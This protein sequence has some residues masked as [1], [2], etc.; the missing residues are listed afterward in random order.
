MTLPALDSGSSGEETVDGSSSDFELALD[1]SDIAPED[2]SGSQVVALDE[3]EFE[4]GEGDLEAVEEGDI[5]AEEEAEVRE[6][7][8]ER[9]VVRERWIKPAP[10]GALPV[11]FMVPCVAIMVVVGIMGWELIQ[12][13]SGFKSSGVMTRAIADMAGLKVK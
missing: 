8:V 12:T 1:D 13:S 6:K 3:E 4:A 2:E 11:A 9:E 5:E 10:W 7:V